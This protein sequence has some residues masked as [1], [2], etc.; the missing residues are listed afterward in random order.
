MLY[1]NIPFTG[2]DKTKSKALE[3]VG[4]PI[5]NVKDTFPWTL[6]NNREEVPYLHMKEYQQNT[7]QLLAGINYYFRQLASGSLGEIK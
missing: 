4:D 6:S 5:I 7:G 2:R 1:K 3:P